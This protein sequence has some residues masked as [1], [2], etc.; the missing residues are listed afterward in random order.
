MLKITIKITLN[1]VEYTVTA[2]VSEFVAFERQ[3]NMPITALAGGATRFE[4]LVFLSHKALQRAGVDVPAA[5]DDAA[6]LDSI[7]SLEPVVDEAV[8]EVPTAPAQSTV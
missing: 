8:A 7:D 3:F 5:F 2:G 4:W 6:F 1:G